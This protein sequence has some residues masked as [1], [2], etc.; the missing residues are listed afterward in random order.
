MEIIRMQAKIDYL[1]GRITESEKKAVT[2]GTYSAAS[3]VD[4][5]NTA[6][7]VSDELLEK[8]RELREKHT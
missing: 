8:L 3:L 4:E 6:G 1:S 2:D 5:T 7:F